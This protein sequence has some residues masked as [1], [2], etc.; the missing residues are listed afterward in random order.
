MVQPGDSDSGQE[1]RYY[2]HEDL[3]LTPYYK[4]A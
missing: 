4:T 3:A 2:S 1:H